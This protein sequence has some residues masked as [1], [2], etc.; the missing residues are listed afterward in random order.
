MEEELRPNPVEV[1]FLALAY[2]RFYDIYEEVMI[3]SF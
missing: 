3:E 1:E 2:N